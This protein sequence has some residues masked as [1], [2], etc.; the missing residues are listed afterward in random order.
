V[1]AAVG[2]EHVR[3][4]LAERPKAL[5]E[6]IAQV[7]V[8]LRAPSV[9]EDEQRVSASS[10]VRRDENLVQVAP[11]EPAVQREARDVGPARAP[12]AAAKVAKGEPADRRKDY[13]RPQR[14]PAHRAR[15]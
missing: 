9:E 14:E 6:R 13:D 10:T 2:E 4:P 12:V 3:R 15:G 1:S 11:H 5:E 8:G 7:R